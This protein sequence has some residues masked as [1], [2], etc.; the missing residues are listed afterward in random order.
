MITEKRTEMHSFQTIDK[1]NVDFHCDGRFP[2]RPT[3]SWFQRRCH[4]D[5]AFLVFAPQGLQ[6]L[7]IPLERL[8]PKKLVLI[9]ATKLAQRYRSRCFTPPP[10]QSTEI[11]LNLYTINLKR[12]DK[13][14]FYF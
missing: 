7:L 12:K 4:R 3:G 13:I 2:G 6:F 8:A 10:F 9:F 14:L 5:V 1:L 11:P